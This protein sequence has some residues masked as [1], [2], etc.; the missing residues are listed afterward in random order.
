VPP[1]AEG[2][3]VGSRLGRKAQEDSPWDARL[4]PMTS[5]PLLTEVAVRQD[6]RLDHAGS[7]EYVRPGWAAS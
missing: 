4:V 1:G 5:V 6:P 7:A 3:A 2:Y